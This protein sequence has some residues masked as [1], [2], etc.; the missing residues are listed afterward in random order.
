MLNPLLLQRAASG[1]H[2]RGGAGDCGQDAPVQQDVGPGGPGGTETQVYL[3]I[4]IMI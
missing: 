3:M 2:L 1:G 4:Y